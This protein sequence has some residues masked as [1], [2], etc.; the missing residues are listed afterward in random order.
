MC[1]DITT[2]AVACATLYYIVCH[3]LTQLCVIVDTTE[4]RLPWTGSAND[5]S[6]HNLHFSIVS[7]VNRRMII[8]KYLVDLH[9]EG[10]FSDRVIT[11]VLCIEDNIEYI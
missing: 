7:Y 6:L 9:S 8:V 5:S 10:I 3:P 1:Y 4:L 2:R 11:Y